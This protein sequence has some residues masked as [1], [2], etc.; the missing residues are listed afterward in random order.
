[1][2]D[3]R[4]PLPASPNT[5]L[6]S[7]SISEPASSSLFD[8]VSSWASENRTT[9]YTIAGAVVIVSGAGIVYYL[10]SSSRFPTDEKK[11]PS[12][13]ERRRAKQ[14]KSK[15]EAVPSSSAPSAT[16]EPD[17]LEGIP[18]V[19]ENSVEQLSSEVI[20]AKWSPSS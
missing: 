10:S 9:A 3:D 7:S 12:K 16:V 8:R 6:Q 15:D 20:F 19:D 11:R 13:K 2:S 1:M 5:G 14:E 17:P 18:D 4:I